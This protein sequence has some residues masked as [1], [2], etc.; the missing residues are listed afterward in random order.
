VRASL[1]L[2][3]TLLILA[4]CATPQAPTTSAARPVIG[5]PLLTNG[6]YWELTSTVTTG[7]YSASTNMTILVASTTDTVNIGAMKFPAVRLEQTEQ[8]KTASGSWSQLLKTWQRPDDGAVLLE[9]LTTML[10]GGPTAHAQYTSLTYDAPCQQYP[11]PLTVGGIYGQVC[12]THLHGGAPSDIA[13]NNFTFAV[14]AKEN[15][16]VPAG[17]FEAYK[18]N[19]TL[20]VN[21]VNPAYQLRWYAPSACG[22]VKALITQGDTTTVTELHRFRCQHPWPAGPASNTGSA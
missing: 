1:L 12:T 8:Q 19:V 16:V 22:E 6:D 15:V 4:G 2:A 7:G 9:N 21:G 11:W 10:G 14:V 18:V 5:P 13:V 20:V 17:T 3:A